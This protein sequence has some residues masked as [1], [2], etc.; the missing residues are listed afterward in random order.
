MVTRAVRKKPRRFVCVL[1]VVLVSLATPALG[2][3][4][5]LDEVQGSYS[6][7]LQAPWFAVKF[8]GTNGSVAIDTETPVYTGDI[9]MNAGGDFSGCQIARVSTLS[10]EAQFSGG[11]NLNTNTNSSLVSDSFTF[12]GSQLSLTQN[13]NLGDPVDP[14][15]V[16]IQLSLNADSAWIQYAYDGEPARIQALSSTYG[17]SEA[18]ATSLVRGDVYGLIAQL[19]QF[20][21]PA[22][23]VVDL[24]RTEGLD[25]LSDLLA[26]L[27]APYSPGP[28]DEAA[29][30]YGIPWTTARHLLRKYG[31][32]VFVSALS[33]SS[34]YKDL[35]ANL[36][37]WEIK[38]RA[39]GSL[40]NTTEALFG[41][42]LVASFKLF[43]PITK[44]QLLDPQLL[45][46]ANIAQVLPDGRLQGLGG[47]YSYIEFRMEPK[48]GV[49]F[50]PIETAVDENTKLDPGEYCAFIVFRN[51]GNDAYSKYKAKFTVNSL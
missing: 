30:K 17:L 32:T 7:Q 46:Y 33:R 51:P 44:R 13:Y 49:Y 11:G 37:G 25:Y 24:A 20:G 2:T 21:Y 5:F 35:A 27:S 15:W 45:P 14:A 38:L 50:A 36:E 8:D 6:L 22:G 31:D 9:T 12:S 40:F 41:D 10:R 42:R 34:D 19:A 28:I 26:K 3:D 29:K 47:Y 23:E 18:E 4:L 16:R 39:G 43:H 1:A 48:T